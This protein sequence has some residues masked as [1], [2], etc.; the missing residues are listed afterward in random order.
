MIKR[1]IQSKVLSESK[2]M[3]VIAITGPRQSGK[4]TLVKSAFPNHQYVNLE[5][6]QTREF[7]SDDP[8]GFIEQFEKSVI[9]DEV[10]YVPDLLS[11]IQVK[12]D[13]D[14]KNGRFILTGSQHFLLHEKI[15]QSLSGRISMFT[16]LPFSIGELRGTRFE[17][18]ASQQ[19]IFNGFYPRIYNEKLD[20][21]KWYQDYISTYIERDVRQIRN[22]GDL[23]LFQTFLKL[24]A[25]RIGQIVNYNELATQLGLALNTIKKWMSVL[26]ASYI[27]QLIQ[28]YYNNF[29]KRLIKSPKLYF[30]DTGLACYLL[31]LRSEQDISIHFLKGSLFENLIVTETL[32]YFYNK[33]IR[34]DIYF[35]RESNGTEIDILVDMGNS[36]NIVEIKSGKT[37][38]P[39]FFQNLRKIKRY[40]DQVPVNAYLVYDGDEEQ[41]RSDSQVISWKSTDKIYMDYQ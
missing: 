36:L 21:T 33:G 3:P 27:I 32:K 2:R 14:N 22:I 41:K 39:D 38:K 35:W 18:D 13:E 15:S 4:T 8:K 31:N 23:K 25:G 37:V 17:Y 29:N 1:T 10:Q 12:V 40:A 9:I 5:N 28:P 16:L 24:C 34:K 26:E 30:I 6:I 7:A 11:Y 19:Y 20:P